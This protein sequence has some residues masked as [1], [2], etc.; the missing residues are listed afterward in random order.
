M[1]VDVDAVRAAV[2]AARKHDVR[3]ERVFESLDF[4]AMTD[5][6]DP[7]VEAEGFDAVIDALAP[8]HSDVDIAEA[9]FHLFWTYDRNMLSVFSEDEVIDAA[10]QRLLSFGAG[11]PADRRGVPGWGWSALLLHQYE[12]GEFLTN[13]QAFRILLAV[14][15]RAPWDDQI[16]EALGDSPLSNPRADPEYARR[17][18]ELAKTEPKIPRAIELDAAY[19]ANTPE[20]RIV[21]DGKAYPPQELFERSPDP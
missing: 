2:Q 14:V 1:S 11:A 21:V 6:L 4:D 10:M 9:L 20:Y 18:D 13:E 7:L 15:D 8:H 16:L 12:W 5:A 3:G 19:W 17:L